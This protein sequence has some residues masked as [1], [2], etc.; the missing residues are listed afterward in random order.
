MGKNGFKMSNDKGMCNNDK[1]IQ[2]QVDVP[3]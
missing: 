2:C 3:N 1:Q